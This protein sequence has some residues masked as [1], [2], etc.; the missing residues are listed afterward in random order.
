MSNPLKKHGFST[1][2]LRLFTRKDFDAFDLI[3]FR[4]SEQAGDESF[5]AL[6]SPDNWSAEAA[7]LL[8]EEAAHQAI[9][10]RTKAYEENTVPSWLWRRTSEG[11][12]STPETGVQQILNRVVGSATYAGWKEDL[13]ADETEARNFYDEARYALAQR[14]IALE[15]SALAA[16][17]LDWAYGFQKPAPELKPVKNART[18][19]ISNATIDAVVSGSTDKNVRSA[20][21][22]FLA[23]A[24][25][26]LTLRFSDVASDW[27]TPNRQSPSAMIDLM[28]CRHNDGSVN[29]EA[30]RHVT[31]LLVMLLDLHDDQT[32]ALAIGFCNLAPLVMALALPY[33]S[34]AAQT[35]AAAISAVI[36]A[37]A[38]ATS[39]ELAGFR[40]A[41]P[42]F[43]SNRDAVLRSL[44]NH[45][46]AAYGDRSDYEKISV[47]PVSLEIEQCPDLALVA[48][49]RRRWNETLE[50]VRQHGL[51]HTQVT[52]LVSSPTLALF[53]E[54]ASQG[55]EPARSLISLRAENETFRR[56]ISPSVTEALGRLGYDRT[57]A[58]AITRYIMGAAT[59]EKAPAINHASLRAHGFDTAALE[60]IEDCLPSVNNLRLAFTPWILGEGFCRKVLKIPAGKLKNPH[61][62]LLKH[63]GFS[64][65][66]IAAA[67]AFC[68]GHDTAKGAPELRP[69]HASIFAHEGEVA[70]EAKIRMAA[71][72]QSFISGDV[73]L[74]LSLA[75]EASAGNEKL[76]LNAW[77][78][79]VKSVMIAYDKIHV[80][81]RAAKTG[82]RVAA[83][84]HTRRPSLPAR[85]SK[86]KAGSRVVSMKSGSAHKPS[87]RNKGK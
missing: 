47:L 55:I 65:A 46:R 87:G 70:D 43:I 2:I 25:Q 5:P 50:L 86:P 33:D 77:R 54:S 85:K 63:L 37:E 14:Y 11:K 7:S 71:A 64:D 66:D 20:W 31:R 1:H 44:R 51:R 49:A 74:N 29:I 28:A 6:E 21:Q 32:E 17:G 26:P 83:F 81:P 8:A 39:A 36:T 68:Y 3:H 42:A 13:F 56:E 67:N 52:A 61:F 79:G 22:K 58:K 34:D 9:P 59:L 48:A 69:Q 45:R 30:L 73:H 84:L 10:A 76:L 82:S 16:L 62:D 41:S 53:M 19:N 38:Y 4:E 24:R 18:V 35:T 72:V 23:P 40:G 57:A 60:R 27:G 15:P 78:H 80:Q 75:A 12:A